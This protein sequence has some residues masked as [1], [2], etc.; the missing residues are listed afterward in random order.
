MLSHLVIAVITSFVFNAQFTVGEGCSIESL[1][2]CFSAVGSFS[3]QL[4]PRDWDAQ[5]RDM[6][7][8]FECF[9]RKESACQPMREIASKMLDSLCSQQ[10]SARKLYD[11]HRKCYDKINEK[12]CTDKFA[13]VI[14]RPA[15]DQAEL[16]ARTCCAS[17]QLVDCTTS[18]IIKQCDAKAASLPQEIMNRSSEANPQMQQ[19]KVQDKKCQPY[20]FTN[21]GN[22]LMVPV[23][24]LFIVTIVSSVQFKILI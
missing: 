24:F 6:R 16:L 9:G 4:I 12:P 22:S 17:K 3:Q 2:A 15:K 10:S 21:S 23:V 18:I 8:G 11:E 20:L 13:E 1:T 7:A 19:C 14:Q 5:C